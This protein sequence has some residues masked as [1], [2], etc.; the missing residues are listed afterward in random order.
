MMSNQTGVPVV[1]GV[2]QNAV[3]GPLVFSLYTND[4]SVDTDPQIS[5]FADDCI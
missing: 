1:S 3:L 4:I 2:P 5:F